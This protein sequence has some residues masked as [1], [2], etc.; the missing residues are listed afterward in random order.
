MPPR[1]LH[2]LQYRKIA[3]FLARCSC[4]SLTWGFCGLVEFRA[5][6]GWV[7]RGKCLNLCTRV[8]LWGWFS[9]QISIMFI[10]K[11]IW[12]IQKHFLLVDDTEFSMFVYVCVGIS[13]SHAYRW[14]CCVLQTVNTQIKQH[15]LGSCMSRVCT[16]CHIEIFRQVSSENPFS[17]ADLMRS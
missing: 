1:G 14:C 9:V 3:L 6:K 12:W 7:L 10:N 16:V 15:Y 13:L 4:M 17:A 2:C 11:M 5:F 8:C